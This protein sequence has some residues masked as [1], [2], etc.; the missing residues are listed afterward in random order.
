MTNNKDQDS[1][2]TSKEL[3]GEEK[4]LHLMDG[5]DNK[6]K[7]T[8]EE[9]LLHVIENGKKNSDNEYPIKTDKSNPSSDENSNTTKDA[10]IEE[11]PSTRFK[12]PLFLSQIKFLSIDF[13]NIDIRKISLATVNKILIVVAAICTIAFAF[14][15]LG[16]KQNVSERID[17]LASMKIEKNSMPISTDKPNLPK[18]NEYIAETQKNNP[19]HLLPENEIKTIDEIIEKPL[20]LK[21]V[22]ILWA[23]NAQAIIEDLNSEKTFIVEDGDVVGDYNVV[24][25]SQLEV[26]LDDNGTEKILK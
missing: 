22:G 1:M 15:I 14:Y 19:F 26:I 11:T 12:I 2:K 3:S 5:S 7:V 25:I 18:I 6:N 20:N 9:K 16:E 17:D 13:T 10:P 4:L 21:L 24:K 8:A 23:D